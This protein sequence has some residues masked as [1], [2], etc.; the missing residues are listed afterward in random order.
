MNPNVSLS[1]IDVN[2]VQKSTGII[3][4]H[5]YKIIFEKLRTGNFVVVSFRENEG[6]LDSNE[7]L[8]NYAKGFEGQ[9]FQPCSW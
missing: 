9:R 1:L 8:Q 5:L 6:P 2:S 4:H 7:I 3:F